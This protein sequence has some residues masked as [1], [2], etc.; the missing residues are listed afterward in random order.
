MNKRVVSLYQAITL[1]TLKQNIMK[2]SILT[3]VT[4]ATL[5][6]CSTEDRAEVVV[7]PTTPTTPTTELTYPVEGDWTHIKNEVY[8]EWGVDTEI[9]QCGNTLEISSSL[10]TKDANCI[11]GGVRNDFL[12]E[13]NNIYIYNWNEDLFVYIDGDFLKREHTGDSPR[14]V[15]IYRR[16]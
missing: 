16:N 1:I 9:I 15:Q 12:N 11:G 13:Q 8:Y 5:F 10:D 4:I 3:F 14:T 7:E 6:S 2:K